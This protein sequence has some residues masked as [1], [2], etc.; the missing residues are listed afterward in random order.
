[1]DISNQV[2]IVSFIFVLF[3]LYKIFNK[4][5]ID[6]AK[7]GSCHL[8]EYERLVEIKTRK[9]WLVSFV[10]IS[11]ISVFSVFFTI[12]GE[13]GVESVSKEIGL[14]LGIMISTLAIIPWF[15]ITYHCSFKKRGTAWLSWTMVMVPLRELMD[16]SK[17]GWSDIGEWNALS[18]FLVLS[19]LSI[20][21]Y[22]LFNCFQLHKVN[23]RR[24][25]I[26]SDILFKDSAECSD[27]V[28]K[29]ENSQSLNDLNE[30][31]GYAVRKWPQWEGQIS[32]VYNKRKER[33]LENRQL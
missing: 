19:F 20:E 27:C 24:K 13:E 17:G 11:L 25:K 15:W 31:F 33:L 14:P 12:V 18:W 8:T 23:S 4:E 22:Y 21:A 30:V 29:I 9:K 28:S 6:N 26:D 10:L 3:V 1:M 5:K 16:L 32:Q 2:S 7:D